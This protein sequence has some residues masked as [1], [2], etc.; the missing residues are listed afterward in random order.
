MLFFYRTVVPLTGYDPS[1]LVLRNSIGGEFGCAMR[2]VR[3]ANVVDH[4][5]LN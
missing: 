4:T 1:C 5:P 3:Y 2:F